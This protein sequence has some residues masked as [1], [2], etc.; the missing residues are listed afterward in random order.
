M[1]NVEI[2]GVDVVH[3]AK[4]QSGDPLHLRVGLQTQDA[5][6][7]RPRD[8]DPQA[9]RRARGPHR[10]RRR[11][12]QIEI[13]TGEC[14]IT[15]DVDRFDVVDGAY[16]VNVGIVGPNGTTIFDWKECAA[17]I[18]VTYE[19]RASGTLLIAPNASAVEPRPW[20]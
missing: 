5:D 14:V 4:L 11:D 19:G 16:Q 13:P 12:A 18:E 15:A 2:L 8:R 17:A 1:K 3:G 6:H 7:R 9:Q 10:P 20:Y